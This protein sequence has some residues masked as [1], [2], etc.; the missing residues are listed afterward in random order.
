M[1]SANPHAAMHVPTVI[2]A[3][4]GAVTCL[5]CHKDAPTKAATANQKTALTAT[6]RVM[7]RFYPIRKDPS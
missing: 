4:A 1:R 6:K 3:N 5:S 2:H 7:P